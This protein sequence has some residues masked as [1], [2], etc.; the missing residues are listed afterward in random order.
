M[1]NIITRTLTYTTADGVTLESYLCLPVQTSLELSGVLVAPEWW[2]L[3]D[4]AKQSAERL[5][6]AGYAALA[7]DLY[8]NARL[9]DDAQ[10]AQTWMEEVLS[11]PLT[12]AERTELALK[13]LSTQ[14]EVNPLSV[15]AIGFY[16]G[17]K[18]VLDMARRGVHLIAV[19]SFHGILAPIAPAQEGIIKA[20]I[21]VEHGEQD[22]LVS[23]DDVAAFKQEM[24]AAKV[25]Y[26]VDV[27]PNAK[28]GFTNPQATHNGEKN[29]ADLAY[30]EAAASIAWQNMLNLLERTL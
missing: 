4:F 22:T 9:T 16:F 10:Q 2:G 21:L 30:N 17:G 15:G 25:Q 6:E 27:F 8:G 11:S 3:S 29:K 28:H 23:M 26:T 5:A 7:M 12:L 18:V 14:E 1:S 24:N 20:E 19:A 13:A